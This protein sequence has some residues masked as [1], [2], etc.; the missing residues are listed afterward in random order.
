MAGKPC[1]RLEWRAHASEAR[2]GL[3]L[4]WGWCGTIVCIFV[5]ICREACEATVA[6]W[7]S[8]DVQCI[9]SVWKS[10]GEELGR[11]Y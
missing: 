9:G 8:I 5:H 10:G 7:S 3:V 2:P 1:S 6:G 11:S 4:E